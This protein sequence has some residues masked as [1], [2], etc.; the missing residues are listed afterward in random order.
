MRLK[1]LV[2]ERVEKRFWAKVNKTDGCWLWTGCLS[3]NR[4]SA[5]QPQFRIANKTFYSHR[6]VWEMTYGDIPAGLNVLHKCDIPFCV[7][8][9]HLFLGTQ[10]DN[11]RDM[12]AKGRRKNP[13]FYGELNG[14][15][16]LTDIKVV[17]IRR[18]SS[19]GVPQRQIA[20]GFHVSQYAVW[21]VI[22]RKTWRHIA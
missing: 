21:A 7:N 2:W 1:D 5:G 18:L 4:R 3:G 13:N 16:K 19:L 9:E 17:E 10:A 22:N 15:H 12:D 20:R 8:P 14:Y 11:I 6:V